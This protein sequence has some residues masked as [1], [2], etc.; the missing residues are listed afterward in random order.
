MVSR[1][2]P[3][4][5]SH[6]DAM[7]ADGSGIGTPL[8]TPDA[9]GSD[10]GAIDPDANP[11]TE[12]GSVQLQLLSHDA[13]IGCEVRRL[14][15]TIDGVSKEIYHYLF[16]GW[17]D[18]GK[19]EAEDRK[20]LLELTRVSR[21][22]AGRSPRI[23]HCSAG[24]GRTGTWIALDFLLRELEE[25]KL[26]DSSYLRAGTPSKANSSSTEIRTWGHSGPPKVSTPDTKDNTDPIYETVNKLREQ[27]M[28]MV[29]NELQYSFLY[30]LLK[31]A[32]V[33]KHTEEESNPAVIIEEPSPKVARKQDPFGGMYEG[34]RIGTVVQ[35]EDTVSEEDTGSEIDADAMDPDKKEDQQDEEDPYAAVAPETIQEGI[36]E[37]QTEGHDHEPE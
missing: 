30:E 14:E 21:R 35:D 3:F 28:M 26:S 23:V 25:G 33:E 37:T 11:G 31:E 13:S 27:R 18:F 12:S 1:D 29:M 9:H 4:Y 19:P 10:T 2:R 20:R 8:E 36:Q 16:N 7:S 6:S 32:F 17:P 22:M 24:V 5:A 15:L 34:T